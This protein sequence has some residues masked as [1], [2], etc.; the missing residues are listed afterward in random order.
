MSL[1]GPLEV[2]I[3]TLPFLVNLKLSLF[4]MLVEKS[5][6]NY[7][8]IYFLTYKTHEEG[9]LEKNSYLFKFPPSPDLTCRIAL[10]LLL[11]YL[12]SSN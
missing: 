9:L 5:S 7:F 2:H 1:R 3:L 12:L 10:D 6:C 4:M 8:R 11:L